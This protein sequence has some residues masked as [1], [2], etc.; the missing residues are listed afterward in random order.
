MKERRYL[1]NSA[2]IEARRIGTSQAYSPPKKLKSNETVN[3]VINRS[4][5]VKHRGK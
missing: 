1:V 2:V 4:V 3:V 5:S